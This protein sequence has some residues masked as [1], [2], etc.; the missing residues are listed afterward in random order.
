MHAPLARVGKTIQ[1]PDCHT[2]NKIKPPKESGAKP[3]GKPAAQAKGQ[4]PEAGDEFAI[5]AAVERPAYRPIVDARGEYAVL[6]ALDPAVRAAGWSHPDQK[7]TAIVDP[8]PE[9]VE[10]EFQIAAPVERLEIKP[11]P[12]K[13]PPPDPE[14]SLYDGRYDDGLIGDG[15]DRRSPEAWKRA[16]FLYGILGFLFQVSTLPRWLS[17][18][19]GLAFVMN[20]GVKGV[21]ISQETQNPSAQIAAI[22]LAGLFSVSFFL[23]LAPF[24][25]A[26]LGIVQDTANGSD[27]VENWPDWNLMEWF[28]PMLFVPMAVFLSGLPGM[29]I[30]ASLLG[31]GL[32]PRIGMFVAAAPLMLSWIALFP[33]VFY[34]MLA[35][36]S[37]MAPV[38]PHTFRSWKAAS[39]GWI[40]FYMYSI[41]LTLLGT[42]AGSFMLVNSIILCSLGA[43]GVVS[44][45]FIYARLLGRLMWYSAQ[46]EAKLEAAKAEE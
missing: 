18:A 29:F 11:E 45:A 37:L 31:T 25:T 23:W 4:A 33:I 14:E 38:S 42:A 27:Q 28:Y 7:A 2:V 35:E 9:E 43:L 12:I 1:C 8:E 16:P 34:S 10:E 20:V 41:V 6:K 22:F 30:T 21:A 13:L 39:E 26:F 15:V 32:D 24:C 19:L 46:K 5:S 3:A 17:Y 44:I 40:L 36:G